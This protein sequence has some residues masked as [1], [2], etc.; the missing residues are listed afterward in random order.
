MTLARWIHPALV[1]GTLL[2]LS[3]IAADASAQCPCPP[4]APNVRAAYDASTVVFIGRVDRVTK[5][6]LKD[7]KYEVK[8]SV[9]RK[10]KGFDEILGENIVLF[11]PIDAKLCGYQFLVGQDYIVYGNGNPAAYLATSCTRTGI[12]DNLLDD[13]DPL[14]SFASGPA[15]SAAPAAQ[16]PPTAPAG[17]ARPMLRK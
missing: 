12:L 3:L 14:T 6:A 7:G 4:P 17:N 8:F 2:P 9:L 10:F 1:F 15:P 5:S 16:Q 11:T 13:I